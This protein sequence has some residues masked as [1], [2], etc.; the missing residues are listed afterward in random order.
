MTH[1]FYI[2][3]ITDER[4]TELPVETVPIVARSRIFSGGKRHHDIVKHMLP[5]AHE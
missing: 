5:A 1:T 3:G 2:I 4:G